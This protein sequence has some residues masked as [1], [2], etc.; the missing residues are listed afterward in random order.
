MS[1]WLSPRSLR[2][3]CSRC[4]IVSAVS[5]IAPVLLAAPAR[6]GSPFQGAEGGHD[7]PPLGDV[8]LAA[9][10]VAV[11]LHGARGD[12]ELGRDLLLAEPALQGARDL[13]LP[14][15]QHRP[16]SGLLY[17]DRHQ[18]SPLWWSRPGRTPSA[19]GHLFRRPAGPPGRTVTLSSGRESSPSHASGRLWARERRDERREPLGAALAPADAGSVQ[20]PALACCLRS[21]PLAGPVASSATA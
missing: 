20:A 3:R 13:P 9:Q 17:F 6:S 12:T 5:A 19:P 10:A 1:F 16:L 21:L 4:P 8:E 18:R 15:G 11:H 7:L 14:L 2:S